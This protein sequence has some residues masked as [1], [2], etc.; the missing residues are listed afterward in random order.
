MYDIQQIPTEHKIQSRKWR[1]GGGSKRAKKKKR[2][3][4]MKSRRFPSSVS[5]DFLKTDYENEGEG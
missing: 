2:I 1:T 5:G 4:T 3:L